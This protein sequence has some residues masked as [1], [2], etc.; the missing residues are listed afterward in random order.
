MKNRD[1]A[2]IL[3]V[4]LAAAGIAILAHIAP[5][6]FLLDTTGTTV[7]RLP[8][9]GARTI[10]LTFDDGPNPTA[11]PQLLDLLKSKQA[12]AT[13]FLIGR[14]VNEETAPIIRRMFDEG[15]SVALHTGDRWLLT[16]TAGSLA[17]KLRED[18]E[19]IQRLT[20][21][22]PCRLFRPHAGWRSI[23]MIRGARQAGFK[24]AGWSWM[25]WDWVWFRE[26]TGARVARQ[27]VANAAP[28]KIIVI[29]DGHHRNPQA[30][31]KYAIEAAAQIIDGLRAKGYRF[32][33]LCD[34]TGALPQ[35]RPS[36]GTPSPENQE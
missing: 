16:R 29:H 14:Y 20:G 7:W 23:P 22:A 30:D 28:G 10:Y 21:H 18:S 9:N 3:A 2:M 1:A 15:H 8:A 4:I 36:Q 19:R 33:G 25:S 11:T 27:V 5:F 17:R 34:A 32:A 6:P 24:I 31:R 35:G 26:R 13:F 12:P